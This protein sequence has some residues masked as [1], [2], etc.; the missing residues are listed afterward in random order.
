MAFKDVTGGLS[1]SLGDFSVAVGK[2]VQEAKKEGVSKDDIKAAVAA[3]Y[4][5]YE[6]ANP[7]EAPQIKR[8]R[9]SGMSIR[10]LPRGARGGK[11]NEGLLQLGGA[12]LLG[13]ALGRSMR[14]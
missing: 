12:L 5:E 7:H 4:D 10:N 8:W 6:R 11:P 14:G 13:L 1:L 9:D 2:G 3:A